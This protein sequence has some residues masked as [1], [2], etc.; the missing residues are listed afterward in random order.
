MKARETTHIKLTLVFIGFQITNQCLDWNRSHHI[1]ESTVFG[2]A[3]AS[4]AKLY[5]KLVAKNGGSVN[6]TP[7]H[8]HPCNDILSDLNTLWL[9]AHRSQYR[10]ENTG[11]VSEDT[12]SELRSKMSLNTSHV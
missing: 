11:N 10:E 5:I 3:E 9:R 6:C 1:L 12:L 8:S 4:S 7:D 2:D